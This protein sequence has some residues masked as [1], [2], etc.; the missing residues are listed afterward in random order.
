[1]TPNQAFDQWYL[2][3]GRDP[4]KTQPVLARLRDAYEAGAASRTPIWQP[5]ETA[6]KD[7]TPILV[8]TIDSDGYACVS[9]IRHMWRV[10]GTEE[11]MWDEMTGWMP[12]SSP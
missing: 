11:K 9:R 6:P 4:Y 8:K 10:M 5:M 12:L 7:G 3:H 2:A 1:M